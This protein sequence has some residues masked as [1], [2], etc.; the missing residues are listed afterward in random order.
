MS[1]IGLVLSERGE[2]DCE[3]LN[4]KQHEQ[5]LAQDSRLEIVLN[6]HGT[7]IEYDR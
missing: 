3:H 5:H 2:S 4:N 7:N 6:E 1:I